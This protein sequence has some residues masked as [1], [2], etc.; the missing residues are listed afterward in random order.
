MGKE[1]FMLT[2]EQAEVICEY[3]GKNVD[4]TEWYEICEML[5]KVIDN[6]VP[7]NF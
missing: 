5:D 7:I 3:F 6:L 2:K 4:E 1:N